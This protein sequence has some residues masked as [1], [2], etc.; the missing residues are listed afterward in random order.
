MPDDVKT[1]AQSIT[2]LICQVS[3]ERAGEMLAKLWDEKLNSRLDWNRMPELVERCHG[4]SEGLLVASEMPGVKPKTVL[5]LMELAKQKIEEG[6][7]WT[8]LMRASL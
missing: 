3:P 1:L 2:D 6:E 4:Y 5:K 7:S 8:A